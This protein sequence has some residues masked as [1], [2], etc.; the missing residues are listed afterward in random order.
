M[1]KTIKIPVVT[2]AVEPDVIGSLELTKSA[3]DELLGQL[4]GSG[5]VCLGASLI[6]GP[7]AKILSVTLHNMPRGGATL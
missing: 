1:S 7:D 3:H 5:D 6:T 4:Q 2:F